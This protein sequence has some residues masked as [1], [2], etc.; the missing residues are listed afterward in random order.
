MG[1]NMPQQAPTAIPQEQGSPLPN[2]EPQPQQQGT[3][4]SDIPHI[5]QMNLQFTMIALLK[6]M[7]NVMTSPANMFEKMKSIPLLAQAVTGIHTAFHNTESLEFEKA[8]PD[9][10]EMEAQIAKQDADH[11][12]ALDLM[13]PNHDEQ[14]AE[15]KLEMEKQKM[16]HDMQLA[17]MKAELEVQKAQ[18]EQQHKD[19]IHQSNLEQQEIQK[20]QTIQQAQQQEE[21][22]TL[23]MSNQQESHEADVKAKKDAASKPE[24]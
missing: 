4:P 18:Q 12:Y 20:A 7:Q 10:G 22:H 9:N 6:Q 3:S 21:N 13:A 24:A 14:L 16:E 8:K 5:L 15:R 2:S 11:K 19:D 23:T 17:E 1:M